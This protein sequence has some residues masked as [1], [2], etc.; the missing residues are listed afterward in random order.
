MKPLL[1]NQRGIEIGMRSQPTQNTPE[2]CLRD[3]VLFRDVPASVASLRGVGGGNFDK[4][5]PGPCEFVTQALNKFAP[6]CIEDASGK[7]AVRADHV[8]DLE[9]LDDDCAVALGIGSAE[10]MNEMF[11]LSPN[12]AVDASNAEFGFFSVLG[13]FLPA[14]D[15]AL[16][17]SKPLHCSGVEAWRLDDCTIG[18]GND[19]GHSAV[20]RNDW[21]VRAIGSTISISHT[22]EANHW[23]PS[24]RIVQVLGFPSSER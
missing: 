2:R 7:S 8:T 20:E 10:I 17:A 19:V 13:P 4:R 3:A 6:S 16:C 9:F 14:R 5:S 12:L 1:Q 24:R 21:A 11:A 15:V 18:V 22:I 23:S